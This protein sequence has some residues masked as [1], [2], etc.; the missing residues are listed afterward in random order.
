[1]GGSFDPPHIGHLFAAEQ[2]K[3]SYFLDKVIFLP[4]N[5]SDDKS[6]PTASPRDRLTMLYLATYSNDAF[7]V[8]DLDIKRG[9]YTYTHQSMK[10][11][12]DIYSEAKLFFITGYDAVKQ[13]KGWHNSEYIFKIARVVGCSRGREEIKKTKD[14][15]GIELFHIPSIDVSSTEC[16]RR[17]RSNITIRYMVPDAVIS[18]I[19][20]LKLYQD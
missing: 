11:I 4:L 9:G 13:I 7:E 2:V 14:D 3:H 1:M 8:S 19:V 15:Y 12:R 16:R 20:Q 6:P 18:Y 17:I 10:E 5:L